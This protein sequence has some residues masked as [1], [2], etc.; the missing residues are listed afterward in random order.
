[1]H[2][3][4]DPASVTV[5][6]G[7]SVF[8]TIHSHASALAFHSSTDDHDELSADGLHITVGNLDK[9]NRSYAARWMI[10]GK[11]CPA[12]LADVIESLPLPA[13]DQTWLENVKA[14]SHFADRYADDWAFRLG[15]PM[16]D[17]PEDVPD[18]PADMTEEYE[19]FMGEAHERFVR[20]RCRSRGEQPLLRGDPLA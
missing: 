1:M 11:A 7:F 19:E 12:S 13:I 3:K 16:S 5:P 20:Q 10:C 2:V 14:Q 6:E 18:V 15:S 9:P 4:Y 17:I 8:G